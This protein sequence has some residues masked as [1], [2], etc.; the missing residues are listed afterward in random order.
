MD[1]LIPKEILKRILFFLIVILILY[2]TTFSNSNGLIL[3]K[4]R[5][6]LNVDLIDAFK[7]RKSTRRFSKKKVSLKDLSTILWSA[8][9]VNRENGKRTAPTP[10]GKYFINIYVVLEKGVYLYNATKHILEFVSAKNV[11]EKIGYQKFIEPVY[12]VL[13]FTADLTKYPYTF[14]KETIIPTAHATAG[15]IA[16]N[17]YLITN[18]LGLGTCLVGFINKKEIRKGLNLKREEIPLYIMPIG[19]PHN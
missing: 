18:A 15:C 14:K 17:V 9:G 11:K 6:K 12:C 7:K 13:V 1:N 19:I 2:E 8:N 5:I 4:P 3:E 10:H 16:E